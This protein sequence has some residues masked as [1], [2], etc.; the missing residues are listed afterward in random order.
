MGSAWVQGYLRGHLWLPLFCVI[1]SQ[2]CCS[3]APPGWHF[4][5]SEVV[6]PRKVSHQWSGAQAQGRLSYRLVFRG[7]RHVLHMK[8]KRNIMP[9]HF[10]VLT[11]NDQGAMQEDYPFVPRDCYYY[12]YLE[13]VPGSTGTLDTCYGGLRGMLQVD[14][15]TYEIKPL[16]ASSRFEHLISLLVMEEPSGIEGCDIGERNHQ[17]YEEAMLSEA[18]RAGPVYLWW[19][20]TKHLKLHYTVAKSLVDNNSNLTSIVENIVILNSIIHTVYIKAF[21]NVNI[22]ILC[23]WDRYDSFNYY[24]KQNIS[25]AIN[26]FGIWKFYAVFHLFPHDASFLLTGD[27]IYQRTYFA[28]QGSLCNPNW[29]A[30][31]VYIARKHI[32]LGALLI[33]HAVCHL[34]GCAHDSSSCHCFRRTSCLMSPEPGLHDMVSNCTFERMQIRFNGWDAC[35]SVRN[36]PYYNFPYETLRC[37]DKIINQ[38]E[39]CDCGSLK[40]CAR[41]PC[42]ETTCALSLGSICDEGGCCKRCK[43]APPGV[44][45][46]DKLGICDLPE[47]CDGKKATCPQDVYIQDGTPCSPLAVCMHGNCSDRDMQCQSLFG[48]KI[49]DGSPACYQQLNRRGDRFGNCGVR[50]VRGG[51][52][53]LPCEED[54]V[55]CGMLHCADVREV[56][57]AG[58]HTTFHQIKVKHIKEENCFGFDAHFGT[59]LPVMGLVVDGATCGPGCYCKNQNCTFF[60]DLNFDCDVKTCNFRGVCNSLKHCHCLKGWKPPSCAERGIGGSIDSGPPPSREYHIQG[61]VVPVINAALVL[62]CM[63]FIFLIIE[64]FLGCCLRVEAMSAELETGPQIIY[65]KSSVKKRPTQKL[66]SKSKSSV[67]P[68]PSQKP[69]SKSLQVQSKSTTTLKTVPE[70]IYIKS[71]LKERPSPKL[72]IKSK[73]SV[74]QTPSQKLS[75]KSKS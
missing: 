49:K 6:V 36:V 51:G 11:N 56:P 3:H 37:G 61:T 31:Y 10:P 16:E 65:I 7:Q 18:P 73:S 55:F 25:D 54:D 41:D 38:K 71:S 59:E 67:K 62:I 20:H 19:P 66:S 52:K 35:L 4:T 30:A 48:Y 27:R 50:A 29:S 74:K 75:S 42:C 17:S 26:E 14:D 43:Y 39:E 5:S 33:A 34:F 69:S 28:F 57:G 2:A 21:L 64:V 8:I 24:R 45:C 46:R 12:S 60:Q 9:R 40:E 23:I 22:R 70:I 58:E 68:M 44:M 1:F 63:R 72:S 47:Y 53:P 32:F 15:F 13:G